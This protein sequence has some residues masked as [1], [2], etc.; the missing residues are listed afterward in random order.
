[1]SIKLVGDAD[2][3]TAVGVQRID[4]QQYCNA[5]LPQVVHARL[6]RRPDPRIRTGEPV[7]IECVQPLQAPRDRVE[8]DGSLAQAGGVG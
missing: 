2:E 3:A 5:T 8:D 4:L 6:R 1:M 7:H